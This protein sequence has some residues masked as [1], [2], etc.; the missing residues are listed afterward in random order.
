MGLSMVLLD[1]EGTRLRNF[2]NPQAE[3]RRCPE[4]HMAEPKWHRLQKH[5]R[6]FY[7]RKMLQIF[8]LVEVNTGT[9]CKAITKKQISW[10]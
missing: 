4:E 6:E 10:A 1:Y 9:R 2:Q 8:F 7:L 5:A 3:E